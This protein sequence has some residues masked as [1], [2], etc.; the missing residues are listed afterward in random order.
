MSTKKSTSVK[1]TSTK[2]N[3]TA[4]A[5]VADRMNMSLAQLWTLSTEDIQADQVSAKLTSAKFKMQGCILDIN[6]QIAEANIEL[7]R[8]KA[9]A[10]TYQASIIANRMNDFDPQVQLDGFSA[11][12]RHA[13]SVAEAEAKV[14]GLQEG[15]DY[16]IALEATL[17]S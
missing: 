11:L 10:S 12:K 8:V 15:L 13:N 16:M 9:G 14:A 1:S 3:T 17:F 6:R 4:N 7:N 5:S 2:A